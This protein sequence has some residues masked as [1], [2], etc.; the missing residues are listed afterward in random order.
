M[1]RDAGFVRAEIWFD[2]EAEE[3]VIG[4]PASAAPRGFGFIERWLEDAIEAELGEQS[5][6]EFERARAVADAEVDVAD[7]TLLHGTT[8][9]VF[10]RG[11]RGGVQRLR[12]GVRAQR[13][14]DVCA[15]RGRRRA[16]LLQ[17]RAGRLL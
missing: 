11:A 17:P 1:E 12:D 2:D 4:S 3:F 13:G 6:V 14:G 16:V 10:L 5:V 9:S 7:E 8:S 15:N